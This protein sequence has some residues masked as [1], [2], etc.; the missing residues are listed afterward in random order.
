VP[1]AFM[2]ENPETWEREG[3]RTQ[4]GGARHYMRS[5]RR[6]RL[7]ERMWLDPPG[8][9][10]FSKVLERGP[11]CPMSTD[12]SASTFQNKAGRQGRFLPPAQRCSIL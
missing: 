3:G 9:T 5:A 11:S 10:S 12:E 7:S 6:H 4:K 2:G 8:E 1:I